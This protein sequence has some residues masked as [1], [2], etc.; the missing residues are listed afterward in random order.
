M[1]RG[2]LHLEFAASLGSLRSSVGSLRS[3]AA[4]CTAEVPGSDRLASVLQQ[5]SAT[6]DRLASVLQQFPATLGNEEFHVQ[7]K[8]LEKVLA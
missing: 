6:L 3:Q 2:A 1:S 5:C 7:K 4:T 8:E